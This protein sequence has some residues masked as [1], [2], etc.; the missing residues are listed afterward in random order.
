MFNVSV[1]SRRT[2]SALSTGA[3]LEEPAAQDGAPVLH[4]S[5]LDVASRRVRQLR[6]T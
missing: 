1:R 5:F 6:D 2:P 3:E 4:S